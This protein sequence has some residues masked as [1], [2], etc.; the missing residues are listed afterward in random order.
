[1]TV[2]ASGC[3]ASA[4]VLGVHMGVDNMVR[5]L[6]EEAIAE[7][8][9]GPDPRVAA[10]FGRIAGRARRVAGGFRLVGKGVWPF[11]S[12]CHHADWDLLIMMIEEPDGSEWIGQAVVPMTELTILDDWHVG[13]ASGTGSNSVMAE[14]LFIP[15]H[16][17]ARSVLHYPETAAT[18]IPI[19]FRITIATSIPLGIARHALEAYLADART[20]LLKQLG[21]PT[22]AET[23]IVHHAVAEAAIRINLIEAF[24]MWARSIVDRYDEPLP[25]AEAAAIR[26]GAAN[27]LRLA[28]EAIEGLYDVSPPGS[29]REDQVI[30]R[31]V[32]EARALER[33]QSSGP[34]LIREVYGRYLCG[35]TAAPTTV[36][37]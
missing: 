1:M 28:R 30:Q 34:L 19:A 32:R 36:F 25:V 29:I 21:Y 26:A 7:V 27:C 13:G 11:N 9:S 15:E 24:I 33:H 23:P 5:G 6:S 22:L 2:V 35:L 12:G 10:V 4:W 8:Y 20:G 3:V 17:V 37:G 16:R 14:D 31:L 18:A